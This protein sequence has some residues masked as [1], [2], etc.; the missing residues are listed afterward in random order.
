MTKVIFQA[1]NIKKHFG[2]VKAV[3]GVSFTL[4]KGECVA[5]A[6]DNG[7]GKTTMVKLISGVY[8]A[9][10]GEMI[11]N[12]QTMNFQSPEEARYKGIETIYQDLALANNLT[13]GENIFLG[14]EPMKKIFGFIPVLNRET[15]AYEAKKVMESLDFHTERF[16]DAV[17]GFSG[18]QRQAV[19]IGRAVYW[20]AKILI[21]DEPTAALGVPEQKKVLQLI[22]RLKKQGHAILFISHNLHDIFEVSD[23]IIV[24]HQGKVAG[25][26]KISN[27]HS[28]EVVRLMIG[29]A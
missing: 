1:K 23:R 19:A 3:D 16:N 14:R 26:R 5:L 6:G 29:G 9:T 15:M 12:D 8:K 10:S 24:M 22:K 20:N 2:S 13:I 25:E 4:T 18:G 21:M 28:D 7:A 27:T 17:S 11:F